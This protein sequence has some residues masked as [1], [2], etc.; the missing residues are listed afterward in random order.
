MP[1]PRR[2]AVPTVAL[3][4]R[5]EPAMNDHRPLPDRPSPSYA[6]IAAIHDE[7]RQRA[8]ALRAQAFTDAAAWLVRVLLT[9]AWA[10]VT[11]LFRPSRRRADG[12][13]PPTRPRRS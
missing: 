7:A 1:F 12:A 13:V 2:G 6:Q 8:A 11:A 9:P 5:Q 3:P 10:G 4:L